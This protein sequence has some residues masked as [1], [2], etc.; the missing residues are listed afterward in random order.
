ME[1]C[2]VMDWNFFHNDQL[3]LDPVQRFLEVW[4][5]L[6]FLEKE[7]D[8]YFCMVHNLDSAWPREQSS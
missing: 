2:E 8:P 7:L 3:I 5:L 1:V 4:E 6:P